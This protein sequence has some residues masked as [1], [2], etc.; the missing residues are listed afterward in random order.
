[1]QLLIQNFVIFKYIVQLR[2]YH[3]HST[4]QT[5]YLLDE[6]TMSYLGLSRNKLSEKWLDHSFVVRYVWKYSFLHNKLFSV[7][8]SEYKISIV[9]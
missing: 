2:F 7:T 6:H 9:S 8:F 5:Y 1:M 4:L 3:L